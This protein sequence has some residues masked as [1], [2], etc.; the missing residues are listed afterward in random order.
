MLRLAN[1][2]F[3]Y[4]IDQTKQFLSRGAIVTQV[5]LTGV[6]CVVADD[7]NNIEGILHSRI[8]ALLCER[9]DILVEISSFLAEVSTEFLYNQP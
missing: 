9:P 2:D 1:H 8:E 7:S 6:D 4:Q 5:D 3:D